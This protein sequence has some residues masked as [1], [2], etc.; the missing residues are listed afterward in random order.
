[1]RAIFAELG[2][3]KAAETLTRAAHLGDI[4]AA[5]TSRF[6]RPAA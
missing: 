4:A 2:V 1:L 5:R 3:H 6:V